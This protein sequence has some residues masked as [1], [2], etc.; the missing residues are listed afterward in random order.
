MKHFP[1]LRSASL[2]LIIAVSTVSLRAQV[3]TGDINGTVRESTGA[4]VADATVTL[5]NAQTGVARTVQTNHDGIYVFPGVIPGTYNLEVAKAGFA[6]VDRVG[7]PVIVGSSISFD[8][9]LKLATAQSTVVVNAAATTLDTQTAGLSTELSETQMVDEPTNGRN[10]TSLL[11]TVPGASPINEGQSAGG[12]SSQPT[13]SFSYPAFSGQNNYSTLFFIDGVNNYG[14]IYAGDNINP[15]IDDISEVDVLHHTDNAAS[16]QVLGATVNVVTKGGTNNI[17]GSAWEFIRNDALDSKGPHVITPK[18]PLHQNQ[19]GFN[20]GAPLVLPFYNGRNRTFLFGSLERFQEDTAN[21]LYY[22]VPTPAQL[23]GDFSSL[24]TQS[25]PVQLYNPFSTRPDPNNPGQYLRDPI[26]GNQMQ[27]LVDQKAAALL[28]I[29]YPAPVQTPY[30]ANVANGVDTSPNIHDQALY[31]LRVDETVSK[32]DSTFVR[33]TKIRTLTETSAGMAGARIQQDPFGYNAGLNYQHLFGSKGVLHGLVGR[34]FLSQ[35]DYAHDSRV[36]S[37][38]TNQYFNPA[39]A[40]GFNS[41]ATPG[42]GPQGC[43]LPALAIPDYPSGSVTDEDS[44]NGVSDDWQFG[45]DISWVFGSHQIKGGVTFSTAG[46]TESAI[47]G[48]VFNYSAIQTANLESEASTGYGLASYLMGLPNQAVHTGSDTTALPGTWVDGGYVQDTWKV[49][50]HFTVNLG[51][52]YDV[53]KF[54][55]TD[56]DGALSATGNFSMRDGDYT[57]QVNP[58]PCSMTKTAPCIPGGTLPAHVDVSN[59]PGGTIWHTQFK[60]VQ[61]RI[62]L[63][64]QITPK[65][66]GHVG[67]GRMVDVWSNVIQHE[68]NITGGWPSVTSWS[69]TPNQVQVTSTVENIAPATTVPGPNPY[70]QLGWYGDPEGKTPYSDQW[71]VGLQ[72]Q[73]APSTV[74]TADYVGSHDGNLAIG[75]LNNVGTTPGSHGS[76]SPYPY[77]VP[78]FYTEYE[79]RSSYNALELTANHRIAQGLTFLVSYTW[80][81]DLNLGADGDFFQGYNLRNPYNLNAD[82]GPAGNNVPQNFSVSG[83]YQPPVHLDNR[84]LNQIVSGW[85]LSGIISAH[86]GTPYTVTLGVD[87]AE[88][89]TS[90]PED[91]P[92]VVGKPKL[93]HPIHN[94]DGSATWF[95]IGAFVAPPPLSHGDEGRNTLRSDPYTDVDA[96][97]A[98]NF[99]IWENKLKLQFRIDSF[100]LG[101]FYQYGVPD[102]TYGTPNFGIAFPGGNRIFQGSIKVLY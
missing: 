99:G 37:A 90:E 70:G 32:T 3:A 74:V 34:N 41:S 86:S 31:T 26:P 73:I 30:A 81:K 44:V 63:T 13:G 88:I 85:I 10:F 101:N 100:N 98:R 62:G 66:V 78:T 80:S 14:G 24:L 20:A 28:A 57:L 23:S 9:D 58:G 5:K 15:I 16:G 19:F 69:E 1:V 47:G 72:A 92:D 97:L 8:F 48:A 96:S 17:H 36:D 84:L 71:N 42:Y 64:Y 22:L 83:V 77:M 102:A 18:T 21:L 40:C 75:T 61:P 33:F 46:Q 52:R 35:K 38:T 39:F 87:N 45:G 4:V 95:N 60:N 54:G 11:I 93:S 53:G 51:L 91:R 55:H 79:G 67:Y 7:I 94:T 56:E 29:E 49:N 82:K 25:V 59:Q 6:T 65:L 89:G 12:W 2:I 43:I 27:S 50:D 76:D 68:V